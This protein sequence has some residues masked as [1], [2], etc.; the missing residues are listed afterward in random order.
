MQPRVAVAV[1]FSEG[2]AIAVSEAK[3]IADRLGVPLTAVHVAPGS[4]S[5]WQLDDERTAWLSLAGLEPAELVLRYGVPWVE[6]LRFANEERP[7]LMVAGSHG[8]TGFQP[9]ATGSTVARLCVVSA[10]P[11][12]VVSQ[13]ALRRS[14][15]DR[16][17]A[18]RDERLNGSETSNDGSRGS[19]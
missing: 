7:I 8:R 5:R 12:M 18:A 19:R 1:D 10:V 17:Q 4:A 15:P 2:A 13:A 14:V 6:L 11:L 3:R 16:G 9:L